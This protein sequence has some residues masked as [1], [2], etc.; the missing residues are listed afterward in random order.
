MHCLTLPG[1]HCLTLPRI[2]AYILH[3]C[4]YHALVLTFLT[5]PGWSVVLHRVDCVPK[6]TFNLTHQ[7]RAQE[8]EHAR[9]LQ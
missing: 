4:L 7:A 2:S 9:P 5:D 1:M 6:S 8:P 3:A